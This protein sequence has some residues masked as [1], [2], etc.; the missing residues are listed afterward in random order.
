[1]N[2]FDSFVKTFTSYFRTDKGL[3][4]LVVILLTAIIT[5]VLG[6]AIPAFGRFLR[7][8]PQFARKFWLMLKKHYQDWRYW[9]HSGAITEIIP[10]GSVQ[11]QRE[12]SSQPNGYKLTFPLT[13]KLEN[14][15]AFNDMSVDCRDMEFGIDSQVV[16]GRQKTYYLKPTTGHTTLWLPPDGK[17]VEKQYIMQGYEEVKPRL[18]NMATCRMTKP[19]SIRVGGVTRPIKIKPFPIAVDWSMIEE[20][21]SHT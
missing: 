1:M 21:I 20:S 16:N 2:W 13:L 7:G 12:T 15:D 14:R 8:V 18:G 5:T 19:G 3:A 11:I 4:I 6:Y 9:N 17:P 10:I